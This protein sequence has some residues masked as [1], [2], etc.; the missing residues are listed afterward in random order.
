M[1]E[2][3]RWLWYIFLVVI[4]IGCSDLR[5]AA[6]VKL[7]TASRHVLNGM[8]LLE[9]GKVEAPLAEFSRALELDPQYAPAYVGLGLVYGFKSV[10][11][12]AMKKMSAAGL[13][14]RNDEQHL[15]IHIGFMRLY[16]M[17]REEISQHWLKKIEEQFHKA[18][19][20]DPE[21]PEPFFYMGLAYKFSFCFDDARKQFI[22]VIELDKEFAKAAA[23]EYAIIQKIERDL[24]D[25]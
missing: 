17:G 4:L 18:V 15:M 21:A 10:Y 20:I 1:R 24:S 2:Q 7:D 6:D 19:L 12:T 5:R 3:I 16:L 23:E 14:A 22:R 11:D 8:K 25:K 9:A 13:Y